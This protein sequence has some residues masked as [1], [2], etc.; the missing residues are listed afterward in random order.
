MKKSLNKRFI[1]CVLILL[2]ISAIIM[3]ATSCDQTPDAPGTP[4][5]TTLPPAGGGDPSEEE[6]TED[7][8]NNVPSFQFPEDEDFGGQQIRIVTQNRSDWAW[9][10][11]MA[12][13]LTGDPI[14]DAIY[15][16]NARVEAGLNVEIVEFHM[17][18]APGAARRAIQAGSDEYD[19]VFTDSSQAGNLA[20]QG[21]YYD[22]HDIL[23]L[24][25]DAH[26]WNQN[27][28]ES[29][30]LVGR[31]FF[32]TSDANLVTND[33]IWV[34]YFN[35]QIQQDL[36]LDCPYTLVREGRWTME[37]FYSM[38]RASAI[39]MTGDGVW[40]AD[41]QW[42]IS[43]HNLG[44]LAFFIGQGGRLTALNDQGEPYFITPDSRFISA[45]YNA[46][47]V[48]NEAEGLYLHAQGSFPGR[49]EEL[50]H[51]TRTFMANMSLFAGETLSHARVFREMTADF[52][53]L[54]HPKYDEA[55]ENYYTLMIDTVPAFGI[56]V[57]VRD[58]G[59]I[60]TFMNAFT[61]VS[62]DILMPAYYEVSLHGRFTRD[63]DS[64]EMLDIIREQRIF[65]RAVLFNWAGYYGSF[66]NHGITNPSPVTIHERFER[67]MDTQ[68]QRTLDAF[69]TLD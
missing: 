43:T 2:M 60:G 53:L 21:M 7:D 51:A 42:G 12:E 57:T 45:F 8:E 13:E 23:E 41:D 9:C 48:M 66:I 6:S 18:D 19:V 33:A 47:R 52:G 37:H 34:I 67:M 40:S 16:R 50:G 36:Q 59:R 64:I 39:D 35:T 24:Q 56:P 27:A 62:A 46:H 26:W 5:T 15:H 38:L 11:I 32:T 3:T 4:E 25:L 28:H 63:E 65:D 1:S 69:M 17:S 61:G 49:T 54:P 55:Q 68:I 31:L 30:E 58:P 10:S 29:A 14:N 20:S 22:L 44:F